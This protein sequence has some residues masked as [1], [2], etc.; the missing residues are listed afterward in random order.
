MIK[1]ENSPMSIHQ[2][3]NTRTVLGIYK[4][5]KLINQVT[6]CYNWI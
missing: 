3:K 6:C 4:K 1:K 2:C 5:K